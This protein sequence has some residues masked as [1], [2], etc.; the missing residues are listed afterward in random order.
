M[1][2]FHKR[3]ALLA[4][5]AAGCGMPLRAA[6]AP[7]AR[8][9]P[10]GAEATP[11]RKLHFPRDH[12]SH[13]QF[14][15]EWWYATG[16][17]HDDAAREL[18][19]Q[20]TFFRASPRLRPGN[21]S[22][23]NPAHIIIAHAA[24]ADPAEGR[25]RHSQRAARAVF[26]LAGAATATTRVWLD[27]WELQ[28][29]QHAYHV[30]IEAS[31]L[32]L[33]LSMAATQ[34]LLLQGSDGYSRKGPEPQAASHYYS[35]PQLAVSGSIRGATGRTAVRGSAWLDHEWS[36]SYLPQGAVGWDWIGINFTDGAALMAFRM[37]G[38]HAAPAL[39]AAATWRDAAGRTR[40]F[41]A[42][43][44]RFRE[45]RSWQSPRT[46]IRYPV[47][48]AVDV[49]ELNIILE[50]LFDDQENDTRATTG[51]IYWEGAVRAYRNRQLLGHGY[52]ELTGY[53]EPLAL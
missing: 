23:F 7:T 16:W 15:I 43:E 27:D 51:A 31:E 53:G 42:G 45:L 9:A 50:P 28:R 2:P 19:F 33:A 38:S 6:E 46:G 1:G 8:R 41:A 30:R 40:K 49:G 52:L 25:L 24:L 14:R 20:I 37:R 11:R 18:G 32:A 48:F 22:A 13:P 3:R 47:A 10:V 17:L 29:D 36:S 21:P 4:L 35:V 34:P 12:G 39:W 5:L 44:V 26:D